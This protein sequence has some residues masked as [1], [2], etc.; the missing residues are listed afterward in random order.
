MFTFKA[1]RTR[2]KENLTVAL[3]QQSGSHTAYDRLVIKGHEVRVQAVDVPVNQNQGTILI[4]GEMIIIKFPAVR[5]TGDQNHS[6]Y[7]FFQKIISNIS[8]KVR[9]IIGESKVCKI[10]GILEGTFNSLEHLDIIGVIEIRKNDSD[11]HIG[12]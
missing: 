5:L 8:L 1:L 9:N 11:V 4:G 3:L 12:I 2:Q 6:F 10:A 7:F